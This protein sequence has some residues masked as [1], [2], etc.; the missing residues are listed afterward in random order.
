MSMGARIRPVFGEAQP[1]MGGDGAPLPEGIVG[2]EPQI[3]WLAEHQ[4]MG[5]VAFR[6]GAR[7]EDELVA[8]WR[9][10]V[11][12][13]ARRDG[14]AYSLEPFPNADPERVEKIQQGA[15]RVLLRHLQGQLALHGAV[16]AAEDG[17]GRD[18]R[19]RAV[20]LI[21]RSGQGKSTLA[22]ALCASGATLL[23]DDAIAMDSSGD[24]RWSVFPTETDHWLD[25][26]AR[27]A[28]GFSGME[29]MR[30]GKWATRAAFVGSEAI[31]LVAV[32]ELAFDAAEKASLVRTRGLNALASLVPQTVRF[33]L[34]D[35]ERH[36]KELAML[37]QLLTDVPTYRLERPR[38][39]HRLN[40]SV[41]LIRGLLRANAESR[42]E[43][44][45]EP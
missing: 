30:E 41:A 16:V 31:E 17:C 21:G 45:D 2:A 10:T 43:S 5:V 9:D 34:D 15:S 23:A 22:A 14:S 6:I 28:L 35:E 42:C 18:Q 44:L 19:R 32:V 38:D 20:A 8:E 12:L 26:D 29:E 36:K 39:L 37:S 25:A 40:E 4:H 33:A 13:V 11:R 27:R 24:G 7:G 1:P 3:R